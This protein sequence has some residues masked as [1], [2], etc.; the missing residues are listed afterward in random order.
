[1]VGPAALVATAAE[2]SDVSSRLRKR[3]CF[4]MVVLP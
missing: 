2:I 4:F 3:Y 1:M